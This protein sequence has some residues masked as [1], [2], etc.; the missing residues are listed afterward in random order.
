MGYTSQARLKSASKSL[1]RLPF[2]KARS[3]PPF[4]GEKSVVSAG[5]TLSIPANAPHSFTNPSQ[6]TARLLCLRPG[7]AGGGLRSGRCPRSDANDSAAQARQSRAGEGH[8]EGPRACPQIPIGAAETLDGS[9]MWIC[10]FQDASSKATFRSIAT[11]SSSTRSSLSNQRSNS[12]S[13]G[14]VRLGSKIVRN[15]VQKIHPATPVA[16]H[17]FFAYFGSRFLQD[18]LQDTL[19]TSAPRSTGREERQ[20]SLVNDS[21]GRRMPD[22]RQNREGKAQKRTPA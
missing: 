21:I 5:E 20:R 13:C 16:S 9:R 8:E 14:T 11:G 12:L 15:D 2:W 1:S 18:F 7:R 22:G 4:R 17:R 6:E 10:L 3:K 19:K